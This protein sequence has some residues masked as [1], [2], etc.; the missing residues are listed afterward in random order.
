M[1]WSAYP[2][3]GSVYESV[4]MYWACMMNKSVEVE[5]WSLSG[6]VYE[7]VGWFLQE[8]LMWDLL[9]P[10]SVDELIDGLYSHVRKRQ[11]NDSRGKAFLSC[12]TLP[13]VVQSLHLPVAVGG[14]LL[15]VRIKLSAET[16][17]MSDFFL[18]ISLMISS[19]IF[20]AFFNQTHLTSLC[21]MI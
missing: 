6:T 15:R 20:L 9:V 1:V 11:R 3:P 4:S 12:Y 17:E 18:L 10:G 16:G 7:P 13:S 14:R 2:V 21:R 8:T 19:L 5:I